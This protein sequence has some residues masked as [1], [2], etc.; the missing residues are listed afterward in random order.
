[1]AEFWKGIVI[2]NYDIK[3]MIM[4]LRKRVRHCRKELDSVR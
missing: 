3:H 2:Q 4:C 1:M